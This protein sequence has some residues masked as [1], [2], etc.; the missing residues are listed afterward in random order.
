METDQNMNAIRET[1]KT[2]TKVRFISNNL[3]LEQLQLGIV[4]EGRNLVHVYVITVF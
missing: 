4:A 2:T 1:S 3:V